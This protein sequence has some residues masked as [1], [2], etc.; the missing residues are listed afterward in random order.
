[1]RVESISTD[2]QVAEFGDPQPGPVG[3]HEHRPVLEVLGGAEEP[4]DLL[5]RK[6]LRQLLGLLGS[7]QRELGRAALQGDAVEE[8]KRARRDVAAA[9]GK[10]ALGEQVQKV[11]LGLFRADP[12]GRSAVVLR[13]RRDRTDVRFACALGHAAD[14]EIV[15]ELLAQRAHRVSPHVIAGT[16]PRESR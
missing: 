5:A 16:F 8:L 12:I 7:R 10:L 15:F 2:L 4:R 1:M 13:E 9:R 3:G 6:D 11:A 14:R